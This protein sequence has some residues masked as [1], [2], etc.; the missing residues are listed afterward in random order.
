VHI[1]F[2]LKYEIDYSLFIQML[3]AGHQAHL[4]H[5]GGNAENIF[6]KGL[7]PEGHGQGKPMN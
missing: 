5:V 7:I 1:K 3:C 6:V 4:I 2:D